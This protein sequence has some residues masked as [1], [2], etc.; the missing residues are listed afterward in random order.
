MLP[1]QDRRSC[2]YHWCG[3]TRRSTPKESEAALEASY[4]LSWG[5]KGRR[6]TYGYSSLAFST[7]TSS[8]CFLCLV[9]PLAK[10]LLQ[11]ATSQTLAQES[12]YFLKMV[13]QD[14]N[15][16]YLV[17][18]IWGVTASSG[19]TLQ[20]SVPEICYSNWTF[21]PLWCVRMAVLPKMS[22]KA[23]VLPEPEHYSFCEYLSKMFD[24]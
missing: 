16:V 17:L 1:P 11:T 12:Q 2:R 7:W 20:P 13:T 14:D 21:L 18:S 4:F 22:S 10:L 24:C 23:L 5:R 15:V 8:R 9:S 3:E 6:C 19:K